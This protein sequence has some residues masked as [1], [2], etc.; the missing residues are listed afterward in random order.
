MR[1]RCRNKSNPCY[2]N[3]GGRGIT[4]CDVWN[5]YCS[6]K[7]WAEDHGYADKLS[8]DRIDVNGNYCPE[9]CRW[10]DQKTQMQNTRKTIKVNGVSMKKWCEDHDINYWAAKS[11]R[12]KHPEMSVEEIINRYKKG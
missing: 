8:I 12:L 7:K 4:I 9:N 11:Y 1:A 5:D 6:F 10:V 2:K 3:Y